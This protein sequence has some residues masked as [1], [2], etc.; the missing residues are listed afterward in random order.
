M[1]ASKT[2]KLSNMKHTTREAWLN[3]CV[4]ELRPI[5]DGI[6]CP[7]PQKIR[8]TMS[9][10][11]KKKIIGVCYNAECSE[12]G[13][14]EI[15]IRLD[16]Q[17]AVEIAAVL[18]HELIH[19]AVGLAEGHKG[20]FKRVA[21]AVGL[22]GRMTSTIPGETLRYKLETIVKDL[23]EFPH[24]RLNM[25]GA[26]SSGPKKQGTRMKKVICAECGYTARVTGKWLEQGTPHCAD[27]THG[28]MVTED[29]EHDPE[30]D[31]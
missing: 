13:T 30:S 5:F 10:T 28:Q 15:L 19:A 3:A 8:V 23:G 11:K 4:Q 12:D 24:A 6:N 29:G 25:D 21:L 18:T 27:I 26:T 17:N 7:L 20:E 9:L 31:E 1:N 14:N 22:E 16:Q 2:L